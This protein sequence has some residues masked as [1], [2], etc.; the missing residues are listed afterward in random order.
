VLA[1][2]EGQQSEGVVVDLDRED[3][4]VSVETPVQAFWFTPDHLFPILLNDDQLMKF[5]FEKKTMDDGS[6]KYGKGPF[7]LLLPAKDDFSTFEIWYRE[8]KRHINHPISVHELQNHHHDMTKMDL[9][10]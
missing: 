4:E 6:V 8:D 3:K 5:G 7:R 1:E 2:F 10:R 9:T